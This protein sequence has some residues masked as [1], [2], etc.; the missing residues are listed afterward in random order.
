MNGAAE[1]ERARVGIERVVTWAV[2][3]ETCAVMVDT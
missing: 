1:K 2:R 3:E